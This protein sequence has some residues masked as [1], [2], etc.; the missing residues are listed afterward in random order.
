[1]HRK[2]KSRWVAIEGSVYTVNR[3]HALTEKPIPDQADAIAF[4]VGEEVANHIV[5]LH[6]SKFQ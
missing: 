1:M 2:L 5:N 6:N 4:N 3:Y